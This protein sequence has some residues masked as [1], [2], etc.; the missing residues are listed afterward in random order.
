MKVINISGQR[1]RN[2]NKK[3]QEEDGERKKHQLEDEE[4]DR[5][6]QTHKR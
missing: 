6:M 4:E 3:L 5:R 1:T 2:H